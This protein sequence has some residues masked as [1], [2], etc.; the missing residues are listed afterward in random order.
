MANRTIIKDG[1]FDWSAGVDSSRATTIQSDLTPNGLKRNQLAWMNNAT[2]RGGGIL[3]R[4]G[5]A[6]LF[7]LIASGALFQ[8]GYLYEPKD[9]SNPYLVVSLSGDIYKAILDS[10]YTV[11]K[12]SSP[13]VKNNTATDY[14][15]FCQAEEFLIIQSGDGTTKPLFWDGTTLRKSIGITNPA[16]PTPANGVNEIPAAY[17]MDYYEGRVW[18]GQGRTVSAGDIVGNHNSGTAPYGYRDSVLNV[19]ENP[20]C[21]G[22]DGFTVPSNAGNIRAIKHTANI[23]TTLGQG[24]LYIFTRK[25]VYSLEVPVTRTDW[26]G[27]DTNNAPK[28]EVVQMVNGA[29]NDRAVV[30]VNGDLFYQSL[31][32][33]IRSLTIAVRNFTQWG[34]KP[35]SANE[36]RALKFTDREKQRFCSG[37]EFQNRLLMSILPKM[38]TDGKNIVSQAIAPLD[39]DIIS[40]F[41]AESAPAWEGMYEGLQILQLFTGDF[42]GFDRAF[43]LAVSPDD[44]SI[45]LWELT[46]DQRFERREGTAVGLPEDRVSWSIEFPAFTW[47]KELELKELSGG[48]LWIDKLLGSVNIAIYWRPDGDPC[49]KK[50]INTTICTAKNCTEAN[51]CTSNYPLTYREGYTTITLPAPSDVCDS[52]RQRPARVAY[53]HQIRIEL[54]GWCRIRGM[55]LHAHLKDQSEYDKLNC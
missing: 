17:A 30:A 52:M 45:N 54:K 23:N 39:F 44:N 4:T 20:L 10:P 38:S 29:V 36:D 7:K 8:G 9:G 49:W 11:T 16:I 47:S 21:F 12:L 55:I 53:Q 34:N 37:I 18:Y 48:R 40:S 2:V 22:G 28:M 32:P 5:W 42:G 24:I 41:D 19:T 25:T 26:I 43:A 14:A 1:S 31:D 13:A 50:W 3:Q 15:Y 51:E 6:K 27:A 33:A 46:T 35:I